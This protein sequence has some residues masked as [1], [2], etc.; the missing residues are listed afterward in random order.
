MVA[1]LQ[2][3]VESLESRLKVAEATAKRWDA[4]EKIMTSLEERMEKMEGWEE[5]KKKMAADME[6]MKGELMVG[7]DEMEKR[8]KEIEGEKLYWGKEILRVTSGLEK[9]LEELKRSQLQEET[10][11]M[12][13]AG[14]AREKKR[15][16][17]VGKKK[18]LVFT[19][20]NGEGATANSIKS[21]MPNE[22]R[23][24]EIEVV[25]AYTMEQAFHMVRRKEVVV[26]GKIV[27]LDNVTND[28][29][30][31][32]EPLEV[33][34]RMGRVLDALEEAEATAV[35][36]VEIKPMR[37]INV[38][39]HNESLH[40]L[41]VARRGVY[42]CHTQIRMEDLT[43]DGF[44]VKRDCAGIV[45][46]TFAYAMMGNPVPRPSKKEDF[47]HPDQWRSAEEYPEIRVRQ[48]RRAHPTHGWNWK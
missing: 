17:E 8:K 21:H 38:I 9:D 7:Q 6:A 12:R 3:R 47:V 2:A 36:A 11:P 16:T 33:A 25:T 34:R 46:R 1:R 24:C 37:H 45:D 31:A 48:D 23:D 15:S 13:V 27:I 40:H 29:R 41:L 39:P 26:E 43:H 42:G 22:E 4:F 10:L 5:E 19:D 35:V 14:E 18:Y 20:S 28:V 32:R 44:H 30:K